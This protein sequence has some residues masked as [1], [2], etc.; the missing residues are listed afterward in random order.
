MFF[1]LVLQLLLGGY[2]RVI[3]KIEKPSM[4]SYCL[5]LTCDRNYLKP[6]LVVASQF[7]KL[8]RP[9]FDIIV[10]TD[11]DVRGGKH[12]FLTYRRLVIP[13]F[14]KALPTSDRLRDYAYW[15]LP[16][17]EE[18]TQEYARVLYLDT[19]I[20]VN[21]AD[22]GGLMDL[23]M[24]GY[25]LAA[26]L[27]VHQITNPY[28]KVAE[29]DALKLDHAGYFNSGVLLVDS[30]AWG[31]AGAYQR[32]AKLSAE[33]GEAFCRHDQSLLNLVF[34]DDWLEF[35][36]VW[37]WQY[38]YRNS[39]LT[40]WV[41]PRLIHFS[42]ARKPWHMPEDAIP[43]RYCEAYSNMLASLGE[44]PAG[45]VNQSPRLRSKMTTMLKN[46]WYYRAHCTHLERFAHDLTTI[47]HGTIDVMQSNQR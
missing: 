12:D 36:P 29:F 44:Q 21:T 20:F 15:R 47:G 9:S 37:N 39:F 10:Y 19:D 33:H 14:I 38:S 17:I 2:G 5:V 8:K 32:I 27:D 7:A 28:R 46:I 34:K 35:S 23:D 6:A 16:A 40:E 4:K 18:L 3:E 30:S 43:R 45:V 26:A 13:E 24:R 25:A 22:I 31:K 41:S 11:E 42:G 1:W